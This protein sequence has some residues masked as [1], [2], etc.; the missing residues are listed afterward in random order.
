MYE[1]LNLVEAATEAGCWILEAIDKSD[2]GIERAQFSGY[3]AHENAM[4]AARA[5]YPTMQI[6]LDRPL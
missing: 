5:L 3:N 6:S 2:G 1:A 4:S